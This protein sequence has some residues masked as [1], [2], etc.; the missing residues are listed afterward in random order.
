MTKM[1]SALMPQPGEKAQRPVHENMKLWLHI[2]PKVAHTN[3]RSY[4]FVFYQARVI[5]NE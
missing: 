4:N 5:Q 3:L 2:F 1:L